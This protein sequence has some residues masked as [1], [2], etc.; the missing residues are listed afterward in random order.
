MATDRPRFTVSLDDET[1]NRVKRFQADG[2]YS[3]RSKAIEALIVNALDKIERSPTT[4]D[5]AI[6][7]SLNV[8]SEERELIEDYRKL[9]KTGRQFIR[10]SMAMAVSTYAGKSDTV[11][12][13]G[14]A[15]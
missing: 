10:Q 4:H 8:S 5:S 11:S 13:M 12:D 7:R 2:A 9:S 15:L 14:T 6:S 3:T 1:F